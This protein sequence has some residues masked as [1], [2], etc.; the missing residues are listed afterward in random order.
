MRNDNNNENNNDN[1][2]DN[3][4]GIDSTMVHGRVLNKEN[5]VVGNCLRSFPGVFGNQRE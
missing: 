2:D 5:V 1:N 4:P 3:K